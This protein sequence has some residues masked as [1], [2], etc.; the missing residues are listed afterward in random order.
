MS[1]I[2]CLSKK[3]KRN[4]RGSSNATPPDAATLTSLS[5]NRHDKR[6]LGAPKP[7]MLINPRGPKIPCLAYAA[8]Y[9]D[10]LGYLTRVARKYG[11]GATV[12]MEDEM[13]RLSMSITG[14]T[15]FDVDVESEAIEVGDAL[16]KVLSATRFNNLLLASTKLAKLPLPANRRFQHAA[17]RLDQFI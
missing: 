11:D 3:W 8:L 15:L 6:Q 14:K 17:K 4:F 7:F 13:T 10:P 1:S 5:H 16:I 2:V 12:D 9:R